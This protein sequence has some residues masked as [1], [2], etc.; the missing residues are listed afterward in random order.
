MKVAA[1]YGKAYNLP[2]G[3][4][5]QL[6]KTV[7]DL[8]LIRRLLLLTR[9][10]KQGERMWTLPR[11]ARVVTGEERAKCALMQVAESVS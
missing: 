2:M 9:S 10:I 7:G 3:T 4:V 6:V 11:V 5:R 8:C 1:R